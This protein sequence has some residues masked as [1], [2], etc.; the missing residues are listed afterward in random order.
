MKSEKE[1]EERLRTISGNYKKVVQANGRDS[2]APGPKIVLTMIDELCW[3][4][5]IK[6]RPVKK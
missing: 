1:I 6:K 5:D 2:N 4:L 3:V